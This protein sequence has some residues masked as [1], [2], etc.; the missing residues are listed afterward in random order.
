MNKT[1]VLFPGGFKP[2]TGAHMA[3]AQRYAQDPNVEQVRLLIGPKDRDGIT[4]EKSAEIFNLLNSNNKIVMQPTEFDSPIT[5]A[6]EY[7]F[8]MPEDATG[9]YAMAASTKGDDYVR[10]KDF[11]PNVDKY[12]TI[13]DKKTRKIPAGIDATEMSVNIDPELYKNG[14]PISAS[15]IRQS[16]ADNDYQT[17]QASYPGYKESII[18]NIWQILRGQQEAVFS[19]Q[20]WRDI[21]Q[22]DAESAPIADLPITYIIGDSLA[23]GI[24]T[25]NPKPGVETHIDQDLSTY[26]YTRG[27]VQVGAGPAAVLGFIN[28]FGDKLANRI[29]ILSSGIA[30]R[31]EKYDIVKTQLDK[32]KSLNCKV[33]LA[34]VAINSTYVEKIGSKIVFKLDLNQF[35]RGQSNYPGFYFLGE[36]KP[37]EDGLHPLSYTN[38]RKQT[39]MIVGNINTAMTEGAMGEKNKETHDAKIKKL[40]HYLDSNRGNSFEY[41][42]SEFAKTV[43]GAPITESL[44]KENYITREELTELETV[45]DGFFTEYGIDI[46]FQGSH[47]HFLDRL[48]DPRNEAPIYMDELKD[49]FHDLSD[50]YGDQI[51]QQLKNNQP[52]AIESDYQFDIPIHMPFML[53]WNARKKMIELIPKTIKKQRRNW[54]ANDPNDVIYRIE[55]IQSTHKTL[56]TEGG[57]GGHMPHPY[58]HHS[59][60]FGDMKE[61]VSR[62]LG[63]YLDLEEAVTEKTDGQN[64]QMTWK[65]G[66]IGFARNKGTII[67]PMTTAELQAKFD[68]RGPI[69]E[70]FGNAGEDLQEAFNG[71]SA[72]TLAD[73]FKNG[74]VFAN[75]E[76]IYPA[77]K[78]VIA[79]ETAVLQFHNLVEYDEAG[80]IVETNA[81]GGGTVQQIIQEANAHLQKTFKI[82]PPQKIKIGRIENFEDQQAAFIDEIDQLRNLHNLKDTDLVTE[83]HKAWWGDIITTKAKEF[84]YAI[85]QDILNILIYRWAF[86]DKSTSITVLK[87]QI[88]NPEFLNWVIEFDKQDFKRYQKQNMEPFET[89]FLR[90]GAV[91][92]KNAENF[93]AVNPSKAVQEIKTELAQLSRELAQT[94][95]IKTLDKLKV[96]LGR[97]QRLGG[98]EAIVPSEGVVFTYRGITYK[99]TGA[100]AP[101]NQI[102]GVLKY[103][104]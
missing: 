15:T 68:N 67:N 97:I 73:I 12:K 32:L 27:I 42:F 38:Y 101:V 33:I 94:N 9:R 62:A 88:T 82:I 44:L 98:F 40:R 80:N 41:D 4:R 75:M 21:I 72:D 91:V 83:Y 20:W 65:N 16:L 52:T 49:L 35:L 29:V 100:F 66:Q 14:N 104:R 30:N 2:I 6:Y 74:R 45:I 54:Q 11:I 3:L 7:L 48:N 39:A 96:E 18:K 77:T 70:A 99:L 26:G 57:A 60:T 87:K 61:I 53:Q 93:L 102:L 84:S 71:I 51:A 25:K 22:E 50:E 23:A 76:I 24:A 37:G 55:N 47:T 90:L 95:D 28:K 89:I 31:P 43:F 17:F 36:F 92:L 46:N 63:G 81:S 78:N 10:T 1:I 86:N 34:G 8:A 58:E 64:I 79:Y 13:G 59:L 56:L 5:A 103:S 85:P 69:S 19:K